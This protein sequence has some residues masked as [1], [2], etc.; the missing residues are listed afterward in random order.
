MAD[1]AFRISAAL[2]KNFTQYKFN[3]NRERGFVH[4]AVDGSC[5]EYIK[6]IWNCRQRTQEI[7]VL[8]CEN[9]FKLGQS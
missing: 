1:F 4:A 8:A 2:L 9:V 3:T 5:F 6:F 7:L